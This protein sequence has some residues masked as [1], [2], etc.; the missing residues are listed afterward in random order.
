M[1]VVLTLT[2]NGA[3]LGTLTTTLDGVRPVIRKRVNQR[4]VSNMIAALG[5]GETYSTSLT[6]G[7][8]FKVAPEQHTAT[9]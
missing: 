8:G 1:K 7:I 9:Y 4:A 5:A 6:N 2:E 3:E